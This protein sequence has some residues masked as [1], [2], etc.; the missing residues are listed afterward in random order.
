[1]WKRRVGE[2]VKS[3]PLFIDMYSTLWVGCYDGFVYILD[4]NTGCV[5]SAVDCEAAVYAG[6]VYSSVR[7]VVYI[8][9]IQGHLHA[10]RAE[11]YD[12]LWTR[13][14]GCP[15]YSTPLV[16]DD[17]ERIAM[18]GVDSCFYCFHQITGEVVWKTSAYKPIFSSPQYFK[19]QSHNG[20]IVGCHDGRVRYFDASTG[21]VHWTRDVGSV[22]FS[23]PYICEDVLIISS[24]AGRVLLLRCCDGIILCDMYLPAEIF[25]SPVIISNQVFIGCRDN[26][27]YCIAII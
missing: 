26:F 13:N 1:V 18:G 24:T 10:I 9:T 11:G 7:D 20:Y 2:V 23:S 4:S 19:S 17:C 27:L 6:I 22:V 16:N 15:I 14:I 3:T 5:R 21:E 25:S 12:I 8:A